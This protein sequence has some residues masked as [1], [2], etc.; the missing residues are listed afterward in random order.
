MLFEEYISSKIPTWKT[1]LSES[2]LEQLK[3]QYNDMIRKKEIVDR[4]FN[5]AFN[6]NKSG[7]DYSTDYDKARE[8]WVESQIIL[9]NT[10]AKINQVIHPQNEEPTEK[11]NKTM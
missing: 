5:M 3:N 1:D 11:I 6:Y 8:N 9:E 2:V 7:I 10:I 4:I